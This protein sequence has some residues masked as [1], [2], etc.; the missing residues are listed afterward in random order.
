MQFCNFKAYNLISRIRSSNNISVSGGVHSRFVFCTSL[1]YGDILRANAHNQFKRNHESSHLPALVQPL[2]HNEVDHEP[3]EAEAGHQ[4]PLHAAQPR[5]QPGGGH[6]H[7]VADNIKGV[8]TP[9]FNVDLPPVLLNRSGFHCICL[10]S[11]HMQSI[12]AFVEVNAE[13]NI[14]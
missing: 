2:P 8:D 5:L 6:Q 7:A 14:N 3:G 1:H 4:L 12:G 9:T 10:I 13:L 11:S